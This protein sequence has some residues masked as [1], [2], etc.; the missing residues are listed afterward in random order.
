[1]NGASG[2]A[3]D[4]LDFIKGRDT[5]ADHFPSGLLECGEQ[6]LFDDLLHGVDRGVVQNDVAQTVIHVQ[7]FVERAATAIAGAKALGTSGGGV[8]RGVRSDE[9]SDASGLSGRHGDFALATIAQH[10]DKALRQHQ[11][12]R[13]GDEIGFDLE[14][15]QSENRGDGVL[16]VKA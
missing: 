4:A 12:Q 15:E 7:Q 10:T 6:S 13:V 8:D 16:R 1:M 14:I 11:V 3:G 2:H 9:T 5:F